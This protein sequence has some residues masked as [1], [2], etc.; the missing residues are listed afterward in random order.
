MELL[1][2]A[3]PGA[4]PGRVIVAEQLGTSTLLHI[5]V[6]GMADLI[7][8]ETRGKAAQKSGADVWLMLDP[9][10][11]HLFGADGNRLAL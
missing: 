5:Q 11:G 3:R 8:V 2:V 10:K 6:P 4:V 9:A 1:A 7:T